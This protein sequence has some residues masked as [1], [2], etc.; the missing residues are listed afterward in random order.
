[1]I[2]YLDSENKIKSQILN[3]LPELKIL[4]LGLNQRNKK[5]QAIENSHEKK[6]KKI[7]VGYDYKVS[8]LHDHNQ[9]ETKTLKSN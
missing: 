2:F 8:D 7:K 6:K 5:I 3:R 9:F 4:S 1:M